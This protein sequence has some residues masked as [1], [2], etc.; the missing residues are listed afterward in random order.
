MTF[1]GPVTPAPVAML[2]R[3]KQYIVETARSIIKDADLDEC[4]KNEMESLG[5]SGLFDL[6]RALVKMQALQIRCIAQEVVV[7]HLHTRMAVD[8]DN[9]KKFKDALRLLNGEVND[10]KA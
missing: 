10:Q 8:S 9:L 7:R 3:D 6:T 5:D 4:S 1:Q 2:M